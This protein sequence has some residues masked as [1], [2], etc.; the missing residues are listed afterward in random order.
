MHEGLPEPEY[1][2][3][4]DTISSAI[5]DELD[6][7]EQR[8]ESEERIPY[9]VVLPVL[10]ESGTFGLL[11]PRE[12]GGSGLS[13]AQY[14]PIIAEFAKIQGG[15]R[16]IVHVHN[17]FAHALSEIGNAEQQA[18]ILPGA[19]TGERS[20]AFALTE[21]EHGSGADLGTTA[22]R[23]GADYVI[24][25]RK[26]LITNSDLA[27][28]FLVLAKTGTAE[29]SALLVER[30]TPGFGIE[31]LPETMGCKGGEHGELTFDGV[32]VPASALVGA[33]GQGQEHLERALEI[34][35]VFIAASSLGT[36]ER[37]LELSLQHAQDRVTF[38][39]PIGQRQA[40]QRYLAEMAID[41]YALRGMLADAA[42]K[43]DAG[44]RIP[45]ES[46]MVKQFGLEAVG[47]VTDRALLVHGGIGY[48][49]RVPIERLYRDARLNWLEEGTPT[50]Q[51]MVAARELLSGYTFDDA[52][53]ASP[54]T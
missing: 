12:Y 31:P 21:P 20:L 38:G 5:W 14:L 33:E 11:V 47:R 4:W 26:W 27:S 37:S 19:A 9:D 15:L 48:T 28:H 53:G 6:P 2:K 13:I 29:V 51:Y 40:V 18:A 46:S 49:R 36:A 23:D 43:W 16:V 25:G 42:A 32:R 50:I 35:R 3:L 22:R 34:S 10:R 41:V 8:I 52:F 39:K 54:A 30:D 45:A 24:D 7:L 44:R 1:R 17:S